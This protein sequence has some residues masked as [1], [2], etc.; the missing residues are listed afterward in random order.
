ML[1]V[2]DCV[3]LGV[4]SGEEDGGAGTDFTAFEDAGVEAREAP[5]RGGFV[6]LAHLGVVEGL[7]DSGTVD[8]EGFAGG[9]GLG[10][11]EDDLAAHAPALAWTDGL[12]GDAGCGQVFAEGSGIEGVALLFELLDAFEG[13]KE[14]GLVGASV[15]A[16]VSESV[17]FEAEGGYGGGLDGAVRY[18]ARSEA[19][20][21][22]SALHV[23]TSG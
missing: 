11:F 12:A 19:D 15:N 7:V 1:S 6:L 13:N 21:R 5:E 2:S 16:R 4:L 8:E 22:D 9:A 20:L 23:L 14:D 18:A 10:D 3:E 17:T